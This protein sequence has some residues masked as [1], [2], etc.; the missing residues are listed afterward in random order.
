MSVRKSWGEKLQQCKAPKIVIL[1]KAWGGMLAGDKMYI[2]SP[3]ELDAAIRLLPSGEVMSI[4][5]LRHLL[6]DEHGCAGTCHLTT[7]MFI[8]IAAEAAREQLDAGASP[9]DVTPFWRVVAPGSPLAKKM[10]VDDVWLAERLAEEQSNHG[11]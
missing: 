8:R 5:E 3:R 1:E 9:A 10:L 2:S 7:S 11:I 4:A 6:A